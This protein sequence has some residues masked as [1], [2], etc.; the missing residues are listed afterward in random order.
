MLQGEVRQTLLTTPMQRQDKNYNWP[1]QKKK[2]ASRW[3]GSSGSSGHRQCQ[4]QKQ[5]CWPVGS[6]HVQCQPRASMG[7]EGG[8]RRYDWGWW[9]GTTSRATKCG[10]FTSVVEQQDK[11]HQ[12][13]HNNKPATKSNTSARPA[14]LGN[15]E[16]PDG[17]S[18][19]RQMATAGGHRWGIAELDRRT[20]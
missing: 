3:S 5:G 4:P 12:N 13:K 17:G 18:Q 10:K 16:W 2:S 20:R 9:K 1:I 6:V 8:Y 15:S 11:C 14:I 7:L 19:S